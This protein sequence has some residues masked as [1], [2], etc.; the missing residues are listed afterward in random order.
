MKTRLADLMTDER[1]A[2]MVEY[3]VVVGTVAVISFGAFIAL[4]IALARNFDFV[5]SNLL[6]PFP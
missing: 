4:G 6:F 3:S 5:R 2:V 1:G